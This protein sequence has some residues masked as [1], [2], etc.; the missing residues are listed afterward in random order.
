M[1]QA[2]YVV[3]L[4]TLICNN[5]TIMP[6]ASRVATNDP[7]LGIIFIIVAMTCITVNDMMIKLLSGNYPLHQMVFIR[8]IIGIT[9]SLALVQM[10]G[11]WRILRTDRPWLHLVRG[12]LL[13]VAN[14]TFFTSLAVIPLGDATALFFVAPLFITLLS[15]LILREKVGMRR[16]SAV[17]VGFAGVIIVQQPW[18][19]EEFG[20]THRIV[21]LLPVIA[22][23]TYAAFQIL[24]RQLGVTAKA[25]ALAV[26]IQGTFI[27]VSVVFWIVAG[28]GRY[29]QGVDD[30]SL[31]FLLR[32]WR[33]P[34]PGDG[35]L[36]IALGALSGI[37]GYS[38]SQA[39]RSAQAA[40]IAPFE[41]V[42][43]PLAVFW[44]WIVWGDLPS[45]TVFCG[46]TLII[47]AGLYVFVR[48]RIRGHGIVQPGP[49]R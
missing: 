3:F 41:Y 25:S 36:F 42:A 28:D 24:T 11:G 15:I 35:Y 37:I 47:S 30:P 22:A 2:R 12:L 18:A 6:N 44:G 13:V 29:A 39:Y 23:F 8:S 5:L 27:I 19:D 38:I 46:I 7:T 14:L 4:N 17:L 16:I 33:W 9:V 40:T 1:G 20:G 48:E 21:L 10:E 34:D 32:A 26:Y 45:F 49:Q 43:M 31:Q